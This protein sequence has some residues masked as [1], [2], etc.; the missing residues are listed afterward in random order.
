MFVGIKQPVDDVH[1]NFFSD[2]YY[3]ASKKST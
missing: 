2:I 1:K 3:F